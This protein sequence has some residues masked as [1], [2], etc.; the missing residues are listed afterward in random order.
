MQV[1]K[2]ELNISPSGIVVRCGKQIIVSARSIGSDSILWFY[3]MIVF[4][5]DLKKS[6]FLGK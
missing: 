5:N 2:K 3:G 6:A 4:R 1:P